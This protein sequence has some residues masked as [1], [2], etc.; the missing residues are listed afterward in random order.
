MTKHNIAS[1]GSAET[2]CQK[3]AASA[4]KLKHRKVTQSITLD[5][6]LWREIDYVAIDSGYGTVENF[7]KQYALESLEMV[8]ELKRERASKTELN[9]G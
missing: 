1:S 7:L 2:F 5:A 4:E 3:F 6:V 9:N 8:A